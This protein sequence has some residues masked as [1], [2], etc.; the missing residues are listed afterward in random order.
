[1]AKKA[2][3]NF[4]GIHPCPKVQFAS[5]GELRFLGGGFAEF[6]FASTYT[7]RRRVFPRDATS[8][9]TNQRP[10]K[11]RRGTAFCQCV[12]GRLVFYAEDK[13]S[14]RCCAP[15]VCG[16]YHEDGRAEFIKESRLFPFGRH[17]HRTKPLLG[18]NIGHTT[19]ICEVYGC[20]V[21]IFLCVRVC[22][23][24]A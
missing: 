23:Q 9:N 3:R 8:Q 13:R 16:V 10:D 18:V 2:S 5:L 24:W 7:I 6:D 4:S 20:E 15:L 21:Y 11:V 1:M 14:S 17:I 19:P 22:A 12:D